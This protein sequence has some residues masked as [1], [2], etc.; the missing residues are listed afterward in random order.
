[1]PGN[2]TCTS[3]TVTPAD[4]RGLALGRDARLRRRASSNAGVVS[5]DTISPGDTL[6]VAGLG[7]RRHRAARRGRPEGDRARGDPGRP[8]AARSSCPTPAGSRP[9]ASTPDELRQEIT[10]EPR[11]PD[12]RPAGRGAPRRRRRRD[13]QRDG[14]GA[15][16]RASIR[17]RRRPGGSRRCWRG[18]AAWRWCPTW[19]R[20]SSSAAAAPGGSGCRTSTTTRATTWRCAPATGS[21]SR[22]TAARSPR[23]APPPAR[24]GCRFNKRDMSALEAIAAAGGLDGRAADPTGVFIFRQEPAEVANRVLGRGDLVGPQRMAYLLDLTQPEGLFSA[25][26]FVIRDEDTIYITEAPLASW[27]R[28]LAV[29]DHRRS[30]ST[31]TRRGRAHRRSRPTRSAVCADGISGN[32]FGITRVAINPSLRLT[33]CFVYRATAAGVRTADTPETIRTRRV[34]PRPARSQTTVAERKRGLG[35]TVDVTSRRAVFMGSAYSPAAPIAAG[36]RIWQVRRRRCTSATA[37]PCTRSPPRKLRFALHGGYLHKPSG[38]FLWYTDGMQYMNH[39]A[40]PLANI[41]LATWPPLR[42]DHTVALRDIDAGEEL[43]E[44]YSFWADGGLAPGPLAPPALPRPLPRA[45]RLPLLAR[46]RSGRG[47]SRGSVGSRRKRRTVAISSSNIDRLRQH[48]G[49]AGRP[50]GGAHVAAGVRGHRDDRRAARRRPCGG[51]RRRRRSRRAAASAG[52]SGSAAGRWRSLISTPSTPSEAT[53][54]S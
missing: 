21:S 20:S 47:L 34:R 7:E 11:G 35:W 1:M 22:R 30:A 18:P 48:A 28:V 40:T 54:G 51:S 26:E 19:R 24:R 38:Q 12:P 39:A 5:P 23:S 45:L 4:R 25:R 17:S 9:R 10:D 42:D 3:S 29:G 37:A 27:S 2:T 6:S 15:G 8:V 14:R 46:D 33:I 49:E 52:P 31:G 41:G 36:T 44:D 50:A 53:T 16:A 43:F 32:L 13:G